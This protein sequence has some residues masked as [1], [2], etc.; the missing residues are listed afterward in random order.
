MDQDMLR[1]DKAR[2]ELH[3]LRLMEWMESADEDRDD[4]G[5]DSRSFFGEEDQRRLKALERDAGGSG[6]RRERKS[7]S[8]P[9]AGHSAVPEEWRLTKGI[10][11]YPWQEEAVKRWLEY[12]RGTVKAVTG[13]GKTELCLAMAERLQ[14]RREPDLRLAV[15][16]PTITLMEQWRD[17]ILERGNLPAKAIARLGG[18]HEE[19]FS[20]GKRILISVLASAREKLPGLVEEAKIGD[21]LFLTVDECHRAGSEENLKVFNTERKFSLGLSATPERSEDMETNGGAG[22][23]DTP[24][25]RELGPIIVRFHLSHAREHDVVPEYSIMHYG[26]CLS[27]KERG[28]YERLSR[29][30]SDARKELQGRAPAGKTSGAAFF[31]WVSN[32]AMRKKSP[33][34]LASQ[35]LAGSSRRK[36]VLYAME[37]RKVAARTLLQREFGENRNAQ[38]ILFHE[39]IMEVMNLFLCFRDAGLGAVAEHS[40]LP[41]RLRK[42]SIELFREGA[43]NIIVSARSLIEGFD[44]P[45]VD[46]AVIVAASTSERQRI[47]SLGRVLRKHKSGAGEEK[48]SVVHILYARD[49]VDEEIYEKQ[50]WDKITGEGRNSYFHWDGL[51]EETHQD[52]PPKHPLPNEEQI[53]ALQLREGEEYPGRYEGDEY[54]C[55]ING[56][57]KNADGALVRDSGN[58]PELIF[59]AKGG[60]YGRFRVTRRKRHVLALRRRGE[61][62]KV[63][64]VT[65]LE[66]EL[67]VEE[68]GDGAGDISGDELRKWAET[69]RPGDPYPET[70]VPMIDDKLAYKRKRGGVVARKIRRGFVYAK[71]E[72]GADDREKGDDAKRIVDAVRRIEVDDPGISISSLA[73]SELKHVLFRARGRL[74]F[75][76]ALH[77]GL[78]FPDTGTQG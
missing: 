2:L 28:A 41:K 65:Q 18:G 7:H 1:G 66:K 63:V 21:R 48:D 20:G 44:V 54:G 27:E 62:W 73:L 68:S 60:E 6:R 57:I 43:A 53:D 40:G 72:E 12:G 19:S 69:A 45:A 70:R 29:Q 37:S 15:V 55:D 78:E 31:K 76:C 33:D 17:K 38:A 26:L 34:G 25:G 36:E 22:Y 30:I 50:D 77:K 16:V 8:P 5:D 61:G 58:L 14:N 39:R 3:Q 13:G 23:D 46:M 35:F 67:N 59:R 74:I 11:L 75:V 24:L 9:D 51:G 47:Q 4:D 42:E 64:F 52:G 56:N 49:T 71:M 10:E 32:E